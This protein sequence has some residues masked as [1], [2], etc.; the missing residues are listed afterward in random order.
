MDHVFVEHGEEGKKAYKSLMVAPDKLSVL[1]SPLALEIFQELARHPCCALDIARNLQQDEQKVYYY[2]RKLE[3]SGIV[4]LSK[5]ERRHGMIAKIYE[6]MAPVISAKLHDDGH[7]LH[8]KQVLHNLELLRFM[9]P[10]LE[11]G[12]LNAVVVI[13]NPYSHGRFDSFSKEAPYAFDFALFLG[14]LLSEF[15][16]PH[17]RLDTEV[18][19][20]DM[21]EN[22]ILIGNIKS[23]VIIDKINDQLPIFFET[24]SEFGAFSSSSGKNYTDPRT[25]LII[26]IKNPF[27]P[28]KRILIIGG[29]GSRGSR[30]AVVALTQHPDKIKH[31][32]KGQDFFCVVKGFD[33]N[34]DGAI[35]E[36]D[37]LE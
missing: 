28:A 13:G 10:F 8:E 15:K 14:N 33:K 27:N 31:P 37:V 6:V 16:F 5:T 3:N 11:N 19:E 9:S 29:V 30:S 12:K 24:K 17:Y 25:G 34:G 26:N 18:T 1:N 35:D 36:I 2:L 23:N 22:L 32:G 4:K 21:Q 7:E 20:P